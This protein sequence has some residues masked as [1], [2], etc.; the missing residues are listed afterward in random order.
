MTGLTPGRQIA[1][2]TYGTR[3][4]IEPAIAL[5]LEL[6]RC[7]FG[8]RLAVPQAFAQLVSDA[9]LEARPIR[10]GMDQMLASRRLWK[11]YKFGMPSRWLYIHDIQKSIGARALED[12]WSACQG[13]D[14][15]VFH[16]M[17][18]FAT[19]VAETLGVPCIMAAFQPLTPTRTFPLFSVTAG[20]FGSAL[21]LLS[22]RMAVVPYV[23]FAPRLN[24]ARRRLL[25]LKSRGLFTDPLAVKGERPP[26]VYGISTA[27]VCQPK[28][29]GSEA[30]ISGYWQDQHEPDFVPPAGLESFLAA[31][32]KPV[33]VGFGSNP[34]RAPDELLRMLSSALTAAD[35]RAVVCMSGAQ[36]K[37][38]TAVH[39]PARIFLSGPLPHPW[40]FLRVA[41]AVHHGGAGTVAASLR[42][43]LPTLVCPLLIDQLWWG[44]RVHSLGAG[45]R[46][47]RLDRLSASNLAA[48]LRDLTSNPAYAAK[49]AEIAAVIA[50][51]N[52]AARAA[53]FIA[54]R[55]NGS[56]RPA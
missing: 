56:V 18:P 35:L 17:L 54:A 6:R 21:N 15:I 36:L 10:A 13:A 4:D 5:G 7:G 16:P 14:A 24:A 3:G 30:L 34:L 48:A 22:Y 29:W 38:L 26:A 12:V 49:A 1:L 33:Y 31:Q 52:G 39:D 46:P 37:S 20:G 43:G 47:I 53:A 45:P 11:Y 27:V 32:S 42:A 40:L 51:E 28:D 50:A 19:D 23:Y 41:A 8:V 44:D 9:G 25:G 2:L 55:L